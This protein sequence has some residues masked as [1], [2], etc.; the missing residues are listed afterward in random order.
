MARVKGAAVQAS[1]S[2][3]KE[4]FWSYVKQHKWMYLLMLPGIIYFIIFKYVPMGGLIISF[5]NY[6]PYLGIAGSEWVG[7]EH[8]KNFFMNPDFKMLLVN[9]FSISILNLVFF[10]PMPIILALLLNEIKNKVVKKSIQTMIY[11]PHF[12]SMVIVASV[13]FTLLNVESGV[14]TQLVAMITGSRPEFLSD[15]KYFRWIIVI[16]NI[17]K[18]TGWGMIIFL[19]AL[20]GVD[21]QLYEAAQVDGA[22]KLRQVWHITLP[23]IKSTIIIML[24]MKVGSLL[25]TGFEQIFLMKNSLNSSVAEVFDT[26]VYTLGISQGAFS[27]STAVGMFKSVV[28]TAM[29]LTTN[30]IC[31][32]CG[33]TGL[34]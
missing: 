28:A 7:L 14:I 13:T 24:I 1:Q 2:Q 3:K 20:A 6:S 34:Y 17:W 19:A 29:V 8:F 33:E 21:T 27:Y 16:Q 22:G 9:T 26:Y 10:F 12:I 15:P 25:N 30:W 31:K 32:K 11:I 18:E 5:Q 4:S 23:A